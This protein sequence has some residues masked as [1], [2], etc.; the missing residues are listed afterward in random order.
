MTALLHHLLIVPVLVPLVVGASLLFLAEQRRARIAL[1]V[2]SVLVQAVA[3]VT[4]L[5]LTTDAM[6]HMW[7]EG[8]GVY[9][10]GAWP[11]P[12]GIVFV[13]DRLAALMLV[14]TALIG[15]AALVYSLAYWDRVAP[16]FHSMLQFLLMGLN[17]ADP[18]MSQVISL[19]TVSNMFTVTNR[20]PASTRRRA[21]RQLMPKRFRP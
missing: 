9:A 21:S 20:T 15:L 11:A 18:W 2:S 17:G 1:A 12:F 7:T 13:V 16:A 5:Y 4:L 6:P 14:L 10:L 3:A 8:V 19:N